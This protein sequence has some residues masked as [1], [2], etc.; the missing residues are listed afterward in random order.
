MKFVPGSPD[1]LEPY[2]EF[3]KFLNPAWPRELPVDAPPADDAEKKETDDAPAE[4][5][6]A[7][8]D[9]TDAPAEET[10][11]VESAAEPDASPGE[12]TDDSIEGES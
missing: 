5:T 4:G 8:A 10:G 6:G 11:V 9:V 7:D 1:S 3:F 12:S 2:E